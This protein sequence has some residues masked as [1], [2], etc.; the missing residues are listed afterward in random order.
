MTILQA[1]VVKPDFTFALLRHGATQW[2]VEGRIQGHRDI[3]LLDQ[4]QMQLSGFRI[5]DDWARLPWY[6]SPL[7][8]T[9]QTA[10]ALDI[11][12]VGVLAPFIEMDWGDWEGQKL[13][14]LRSQLGTEMTA[15]EER[16]WDFRPD[17]GESPRDVLSRLRTFLAQWRDGNFG[18]VTH[19]GLIRAVYAGA[20]G[21]DMTGKIP[22]KLRWDAVHVFR[23]SAKDGLS[24]V[25]LNIPFVPIR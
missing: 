24:I 14:A 23:W 18:V 11:T 6:T 20:S 7:K 17:N 22:H 3:G 15:N 9:Q 1:M 21:W 5:P 19:K 25:Q 10:A 13:S 4:S 12:P 8:R 16:G 2:N